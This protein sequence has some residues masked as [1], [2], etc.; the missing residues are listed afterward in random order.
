MADFVLE[1]ING[2]Q[3]Y[4][5]P[6]SGTTTGL[7]VYVDPPVQLDVVAQ[8]PEQHYKIGGTDPVADPTVLVWYDTLGQ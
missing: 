5:L 1:I 2:S 6:V 3:A 7:E 8:L 4:S